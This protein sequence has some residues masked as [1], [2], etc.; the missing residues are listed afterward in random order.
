MNTWQRNLVVVALSQ[1]LTMLGF[2]FA[3]PFAPY[4]IQSLGVTEPNELKMWVAFFT[5]AASLTLAI[6][7]PIWGAIGDRYGRRLMLLRANFGGML[8]VMLMGVTPNVQILILLRLLQG[9][10]TGT[11][12]AAQTF[13]SVH[14]PQGRSG[15]V[16]GTIS[17]AVFSG[18]M[19]GAFVGGLFAEWFGYRMSFI[20][21]G[22]F[23]L[24][25]G[26]LILFGTSEKFVRPIEEEIYSM[27]DRVRVFWGKIGPAIPILA[28]MA[29]MG[30]VRM[31]DHAWLPL[32]VQEIHGS[33]KGAS[34]RSG[35]LA[36]VSGIAG[37]MAG[38]ILGRIADRIAPPRIGKISAFGAGVM[39]IVVGLAHGFGLLFFGRF[40]ATFCA[41]GL[42]PVFHIW[43]ARTTPAESRGFIFGWAVTAKALGWMTA[44]LVSGLVAWGLGLRAVFFTAAA[45]F[46]L[47]I[48]L[49][50]LIV[51]YLPQPT[52]TT[53]KTELK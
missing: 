44:P 21:S 28:L 39:M 35:A 42:D 41:G 32:L 50:S 25:S 3:M 5:A 48:P 37:F 6:F 10:L 24:A 1:F 33:L 27:E 30:F 20:V 18:S 23:M 46:F 31:F 43:L 38:P 47:L 13:V 53:G 16:L 34:I 49:I 2:S 51:R 15:M 40:G 9:T 4:Y 17:A 11:T 8:I 22:I 12:N 26:L 7:A 52:P 19:A 45:C 14:S 29:A 36:A